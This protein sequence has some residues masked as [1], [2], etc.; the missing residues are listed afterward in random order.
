[1]SA[2]YP[3]EIRSQLYHRLN[4]IGKGYGACFNRSD[5]YLPNSRRA[6]MLVIQKFHNCP[7]WE[8][9]KMKHYNLDVIIS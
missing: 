7:G 3:P 2:E 1:M 4:E 5:G 9:Y 6:L 8:R